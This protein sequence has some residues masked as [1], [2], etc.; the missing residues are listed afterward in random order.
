[1]TVINVIRQSTGVHTLS[2]AIAYAPD[3][4]E[5]QGPKLFAL[6]HLPAII[7]VR[8]PMLAAPLLAEMLGRVVG[9]YDELRSSIAEV[10]QT[11]MP[12]I[13]RMLQG[14]QEPE[15]FDIVV[16]G[17]SRF[18]GP[19]SFVM[20]THDRYGKAWIIQDHGDL[21]LSPLNDEIEQAITSEFRGRGIDD[22]DPVVDGVRMI[23]IQRENWS[24]GDA[25]LPGGF[26]QLMS[27]TGG[28]ITTRIVHRWPAP[29]AP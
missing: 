16:G 7:G 26:I 11:Y 28:S 17:I 23:E 25:T 24:F 4:R 6:P 15:T 9:S 3:G 1:V 21:V 27:I 19:D 2:D 5:L 29:A 13:V 18:A 14:N 22:L 20:S 8:G 10:V 12:Q